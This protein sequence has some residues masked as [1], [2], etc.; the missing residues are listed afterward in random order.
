MGCVWREICTLCGTVPT[1]LVGYVASCNTRHVEML[2][3]AIVASGHVRTTGCGDRG[4]HRRCMMVNM[5][6][7]DLPVVLLQNHD[8]RVHKLVCLQRMHDV[9]D[10]AY[11]AH[12]R[13]QGD[14]PS[15]LPCAISAHGGSDSIT[16]RTGYTGTFV[17][18]SYVVHIR[19]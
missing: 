6:E 13:A 8:E 9:T 12:L 7:R 14:Q 16:R 5:Q 1:F 19:I 10:E 18:L 4:A 15:P 2:W 17:V 3:Q 11:T